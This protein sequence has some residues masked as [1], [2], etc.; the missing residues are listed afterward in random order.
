MCIYIY[1]HMHTYAYMHI[2]IYICIYTCYALL[3]HRYYIIICL[4]SK[5]ITHYTIMYTQTYKLN[6][7]TPEG[8]PVI[9]NQCTLHVCIH[10]ASYTYIHV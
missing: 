8:T 1:M 3:M 4:Q 5:L 10:H 7:R 6:T 2:Y 9:T